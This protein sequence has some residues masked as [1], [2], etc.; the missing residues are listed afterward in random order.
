MPGS[1]LVRCLLLD[2][3][4]RG[5][6]NLSVFSRNLGLF[7]AAFAL[8]FARPATAEVGDRL[9]VLRE[10]RTQAL[11]ARGPATYAAVRRLWLQWDQGDP[12]D[13]EEALAEVATS[14]AAS[15][16]E[17]VYAQLLQAYAKRR[18]GDL[19]GAKTLIEGLGYVERWMVVGPFGNEGKTGLLLPFGPEE[20]RDSSPNLL[21]AYDGKE[22]T[23]RWRVVPHTASFSWLDFGALIRPTEKVCAYA[24][25][26]VRDGG[27]PTE[28]ARSRPI[29]IWA[30]SAGA[31]RVFWN[32]EEVLR[33][34]AY[35]DLDADRL[36]TTVS[37]Q[38]GWNRLLVKAC[39]DEAA[40]MLSVRLADAD[41]APDPRLVTDP[42]PVASA[43]AGSRRGTLDASVAR[44]DDPPAK[45]RSAETPFAMAAAARYTSCRWALPAAAP[46][47]PLSV[48][49]TTA[50]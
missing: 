17:R 44:P 30:G 5:T 13:V 2:A 50:R 29:S 23:V 46:R 7:A 22:R 48:P 36:A 4:T 24:T 3:G 39:G 11:A 6:D 42:N 41:G 14:P 47:L 12:A 49:P 43:E 15:A 10:L 40:P 16:P 19:E 38:P 21:R 35:R 20:D 25:T 32:G 18:R 34:E 37:L 31:V 45:S 28:A 27:S 8:A 9:G 33:D 1:A 26:Y